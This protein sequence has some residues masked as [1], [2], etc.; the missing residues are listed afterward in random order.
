MCGRFT[1][2]H[3]EVEVQERFEVTD[4]YFK[5][6]PRY[7]IAPTQ[8]VA[9]VRPSEA[10]QRMLIGY[11]WGLVP[12]WASDPT[13]G[14]KLIN[15]RVE[16]LLEKPSFKSALARRRCLIP[17]DGF[18]EWDKT[19]RNKQPV[20]IRLRKPRLFGFAGL[21]DEWQTP[22]GSPLHTF[23]I[24][25]TTPNPLIAPIHHRMAVILNPEAEKHWLN[26]QLTDTSKLL[27][28]LQPYPDT[29][30]E[31]AHVAPL[32]NSVAIDSPQCIEPAEYQM[33]LFFG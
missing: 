9:I 2:F 7:N 15:A 31:L 21:W 23:T 33:S 32:V 24:I 14:S 3:D 22:D 5:V 10:G 29:E 12:S 18:Y 13:I 20:Y 6:Q 26:P 27:S 25:T 28:L 30:M 11:R 1:L 8:T 19:G 16:T 17:A 4:C